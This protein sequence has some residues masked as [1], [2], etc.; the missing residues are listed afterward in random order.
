MSND[1]VA[2]TIM[3]QGIRIKLSVECWVYACLTERLR[4]RDL[5]SKPDLSKVN[6]VPTSP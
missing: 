5:R 4:T 3:L 2:P 6:R 1:D